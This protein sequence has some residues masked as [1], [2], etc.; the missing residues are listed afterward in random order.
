MSFVTSAPAARIEEV[1]VETNSERAKRPVYWVARG[2]QNV[3][4]LPWWSSYP[5]EA[6]LHWGLRVGPY[7]WELAADKKNGGKIIKNCLPIAEWWEPSL[8]PELVGCVTM[9]DTYIDYCGQ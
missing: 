4:G 3:L 7:L 6:N 1:L 5:E 9:T 2:L 8:G